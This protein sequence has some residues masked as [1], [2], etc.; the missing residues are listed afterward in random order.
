M[1][2]CS[3]PVQLLVSAVSRKIS[4]RLSDEV[5]LSAN[6]ALDLEGIRRIG[7]KLLPDFNSFSI[8]FLLV[9]LVGGRYILDSAT[10]P[11]WL[12]VWVQGGAYRIELNELAESSRAFEPKWIQLCSKNEV[13]SVVLLMAD[14]SIH[15]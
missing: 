9:E 11:F 5:D 6:Y 8:Y 13:E 12:E 7:S 2:R 1:N 10:N 15:V 14:I 4:L 3:T